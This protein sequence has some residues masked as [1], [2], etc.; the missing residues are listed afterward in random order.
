MLNSNSSSSVGGLAQNSVVLKK[1]K[2]VWE[3]GY[4]NTQQDNVVNGG[5]DS[6]LV[7]NGFDASNIAVTGNTVAK[8][9][10]AA[11]VA[12]LAANSGT[13]WTNEQYVADQM[14]KVDPN[15]GTPPPPAEQGWFDVAPGAQTS[16]FA[17]TLGGIGSGVQGLAALGSMYY[18]SKNYKLQKEAAELEKDRYN[19]A[20]KAD[21]AATEN[22]QKFAA[23]VG[24][25]ATYVG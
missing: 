13:G 17:S 9:V 12:G 21:K 18:G 10:T 25:G 3:Q 14:G 19:R 6:S 11:P 5:A 16:K 24:G 8:P 23:N 4:Y 1:P 22:K 20:V 7:T 2:Y 15:A